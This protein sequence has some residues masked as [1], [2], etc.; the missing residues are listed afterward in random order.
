MRNKIEPE[1]FIQGE[2][3]YARVDLPPLPRSLGEALAALKADE[4]LIEILGEEFVGLYSALKGNEVA[5][6]PTTSPIGK[7][8]SIWSC[9]KLD[10][11]QRNR[12]LNRSATSGGSQVPDDSGSVSKGPTGWPRN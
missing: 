10:L 1:Y 8:E 7:C 4:A 9:S 2:D 12:T 3:A 6:S 5:R 11:I